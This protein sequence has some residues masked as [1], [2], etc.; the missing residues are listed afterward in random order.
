MIVSEAYLR[1]ANTL[2]PGRRKDLAHLAFPIAERA[3]QE[4]F[5]SYGTERIAE[6]VVEEGSTKLKARIRTSAIAVVSLIA[7][8]GTVRSGLDYMWRDGRSAATWMVDHIEPILP[9]HPGYRRRH[10]PAPTRLKKLFD[11]VET[12]RLS[13][14]EAMERAAN[15]LNEYRETHET[16]QRVLAAIE[17]ELNSIVPRKSLQTHHGERIPRPHRPSPIRAS[18]SVTIF[19][20]PR[21]R[22]LIVVESQ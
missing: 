9:E 4:F 11:S 13:V 3:A 15:I 2:G 19:R 10:S 12:G 17:H 8:Y 20:D 18:G 14:D 6:V 7:G 16:I 1:L 22:R 21:T 5:A